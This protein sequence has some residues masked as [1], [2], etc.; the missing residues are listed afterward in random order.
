MLTVLSVSEVPREGFHQTEV[1]EVKPVTGTDGGES[2]HR[3]HPREGLPCSVYPQIRKCLKKISV[4]GN[5]VCQREEIREGIE[6]NPMERE[7]TVLTVSEVSHEALV[8]VI[9]G[10]DWAPHDYSTD[11]SGNVSQEFCQRGPA[12]H[13][14]TK[15][16]VRSPRKYSASSLQYPHV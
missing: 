9:G 2:H 11:S 1:V 15:S 10:N 8:E 14:G 5:E 7:E 16:V 3:R 12:M 13:A 4:K 6:V